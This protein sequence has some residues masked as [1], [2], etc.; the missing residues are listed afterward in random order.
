VAVIY[1]RAPGC[2]SGLSP[3]R[4]LFPGLPSLEAAAIYAGIAYG[5]EKVRKHYVEI[6]LEARISPGLAISL[7][8]LFVFEDYFYYCE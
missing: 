7:F 4:C 5:A 6:P 8:L 2:Y 1:L 3:H